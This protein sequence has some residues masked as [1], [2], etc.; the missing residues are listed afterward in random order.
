MPERAPRCAKIGA[1]SMRKSSRKVLV[2]D[3]REHVK[4]HK[5]RIFAGPERPQNTQRIKEDADVERKLIQRSSRPGASVHAQEGTT[6]QLRATPDTTRAARRRNS[7]RRIWSSSTS[8]RKPSARCPESTSSTLGTPTGSGTQYGRRCSGGERGQLRAPKEPS[9][10]LMSR[11]R[12][13]ARRAV[14]RP[15]CT[16]TENPALSGRRK[17]LGRSRVR[18]HPARPAPAGG[19]RDSLRSADDCRIHNKGE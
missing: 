1:G 14:P 3:A 5:V 12:R 2:C 10:D 16:D 8:W 15:V 6:E 4:G 19:C 13:P 9:R 18:S 7:R 11:C 17:L